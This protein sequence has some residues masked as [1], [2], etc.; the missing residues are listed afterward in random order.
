V[1]WHGRQLALRLVPVEWQASAA[2]R[3]LASTT[4]RTSERRCHRRPPRHSVLLR[5]SQRNCDHRAHPS[6]RICPTSCRSDRDR[7][8]PSASP[9]SRQQSATTTD[10][11]GDVGM[12]PEPLG[13]G[14]PL[15][16]P[17]TTMTTP[18]C[19]PR[20]LQRWPPTLARTRFLLVPRDSGSGH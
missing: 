17:K 15:R 5:Q 14:P 10:V 20:R 16:R 3:A 2:L 9:T 8:P 18:P 12:T 19:P 1:P 4:A 11:D 7:V 13:S 6:N